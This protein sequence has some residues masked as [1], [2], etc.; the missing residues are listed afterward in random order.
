MTSTTTADD[1]LVAGETGSESSSGNHS[2]GSR[3]RLLIGWAARLVLVAVVSAAV[4]AAICLLIAVVIWFTTIKGDS[5]ILDALRAGGLAWVAGQGVPVLLNAVTIGVLPWGLGLISFGILLVG[6]RRVARR[7]DVRRS[8]DLALVAVAVV[9]GAF[10]FGVAVSWIAD[11]AWQP[12]ARVIAVEAVLRGT[13]LA[14]AGMGIGAYLGVSDAAEE[15]EDDVHVP[16]L[17]AMV[18]AVLRAGTIAALAL[19]GI[20]AFAAA[21][22]LLTHFDDAVTIQQSLAVGAAGGLGLVLLC[23]AYVPVLAVWGAAYVIGAGVIIGPGATATPFVAVT[24]PT[25][26]PAM[27]L[28]AAVPQQATPLA[29]LLPVLAIVVGL[30]TGLALARGQRGTPRLLRAG[31]AICAAAVAGLLMALAAFVTAGPLGD[32]RLVYLGAVPVTVGVLA[33]GLVLLGAV[34]A[35]LLGSERRRSNHLAVAPVVIASEDE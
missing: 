9:V 22:S 6:T 27:P 10:A 15:R 5:A 30:F 23:L 25:T 3:A 2:G 19:L 11:M 1:S 21:I 17:P 33:F 26:L 4:S 7:F 14:L 18:L 31:L 28:L 16:L 34:P 32:Q 13:G 8:M 12:D 29:W 24:A 35:A 20:G